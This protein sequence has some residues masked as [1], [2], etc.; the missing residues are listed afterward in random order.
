MYFMLVKSRIKNY[1]ISLISTLV[2]LRIFLF[3]SPSTNLNIGKYNIHHLFVGAF[4][5]II[6]L[7]LLILSIVNNFIVVLAG[8]S[9]ALVLDEIIYLIATDGSDTSY[10]TAASLWGAIILTI[11]IVL[12]TF[13]LYNTN[14]QKVRE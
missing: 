8:I 5:S 9:S 10:L 1:I 6:I 7:I 11:I 4:L 2:L 14:K 13:I 3:L 12:L